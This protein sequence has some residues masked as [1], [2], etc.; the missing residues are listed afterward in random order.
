MKV[1]ETKQDAI[2]HLMNTQGMNETQAIETVERIMRKNGWVTDKNNR[3]C[4]FAIG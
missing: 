4:T 3:I 2:Q 1:I